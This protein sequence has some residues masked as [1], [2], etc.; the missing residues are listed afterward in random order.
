MRLIDQSGLQYLKNLLSRKLPSR[1]KTRN[2]S[3]EAV[4]MPDFRLRR[5]DKNEA[6]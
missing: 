2:F 4:T 6:T 1:E 5:A 3:I